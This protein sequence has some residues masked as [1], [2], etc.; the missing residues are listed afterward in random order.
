MELVDIGRVLVRQRVGL[1]IALVLAVLAGLAV[2]YHISV[3]PF[4]L[5]ERVSTTS[6]A[7]T[8]L[9]LDAPEQPPT[10][11]LDSGVAD[12]LG[13]RAG[14]VADLM[15]T[16]RVR[17]AI[18]KRS[19]IAP[20]E[21]AILSPASGAP[22]LPV[23]LGVEA[24]D[25]ARLTSEPYVLALA[26]DPKIPI[27]SFSAIAPDA[28]SARR[29]A[30]AATE[31]YKAI[32]ESDADNAPPKFRLS[33]VDLGLIRTSTTVDRPSKAIGVAA[34]IAVFTLIAALLVLVAGI[35]GRLSRRP[36]GGGMA[37]FSSLN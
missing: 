10:V 25:A 12:T 20:S 13:L 37:Q 8:R 16:D 3:S 33:V 34:A 17:E 36:T 5:S 21:L 9:Q 15:A 22:P 29:I 23:P 26:A 18:A 14:L 24:A 11:D 31:S 35:R 4:G 7:H 6:A 1:A 19:G 27:V 28:A 32:V 30:R 2:N